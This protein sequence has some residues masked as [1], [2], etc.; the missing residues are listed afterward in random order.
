[1]TRASDH[2]RA[3]GEW[4]RKL[5]CGVSGLL[6][7]E[8]LSGLA[9]LLLPFSVVAQVTVLVHTAAGRYRIRSRRPD[10]AAPGLAVTGNGE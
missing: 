3:H 8:T 6:V 2:D 4:S 9:I 5:A 10:A 1:M 7:F